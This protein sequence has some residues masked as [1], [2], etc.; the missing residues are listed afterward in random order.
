MMDL[1]GWHGFQRNR[2][3]ERKNAGRGWLLLA[4]VG[5]SLL[6]SCPG[7]LADEVTMANGDVITGEILTL[8]GG[9][10]KVKTPYNAELELDWASVK[11]IR[12]DVPVELVL[13]DERHVK[14]TLETSPD[15][16]LQVVTEAEGPVL[17]GAPSLV[18]GM[19]PPEVKWINYTGDVLAGASYLT[20][21][22]ET[23]SLN[24]S[25]K[26]IART[27]RHRGTLRAGWYYAET[28]NI[29][30]ARRLTGSAKY[31]F[32][33]TEKLYIYLNGLFESDEF[34]DLD[35]R[36]TIGPGVGYQFFDNDRLK[37]AAEAGYS[38]VNE[39]FKVAPDNDYSSARWS[40]DFNWDIVPKKIAL[41]HFNEGYLSVEDTSDMSVYTEQGL[42]FNVWKNFGTT[43][44]AN[45]TY[46]NNPS[47]G[48]DKTDTALI[49]GLTYTYDI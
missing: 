12:S 40:V 4:F 29:V 8:D 13:E 42:R 33:A 22:T 37:L 25:G 26:F 7:V 23:T 24:L 5:L 41:F 47:P 16:T 48:A 17:I 39:N 2:E 36:S 10:L 15:G 35:L 44:Q 43:F 49:F 9:K 19:N 21:N 3:T 11:S 14:G 27:K 45:I 1:C 20:G 18:T 6:V 31:D 28:E 30:T 34:K 32:F 38:Y 46:D